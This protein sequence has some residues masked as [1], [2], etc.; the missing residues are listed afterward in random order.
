MS[1]LRGLSPY[2][3]FIKLSRTILGRRF[4]VLR[5]CKILQR[6]KNEQTNKNALRQIKYTFC[7]TSTFTSVVHSFQGMQ[8]N[9]VKIRNKEVLRRDGMK[10]FSS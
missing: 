4:G 5:T 9:L 7:L 3:H 1:L 8:P 10:K 2:F 6:K